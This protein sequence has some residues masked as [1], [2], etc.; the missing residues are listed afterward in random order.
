MNRAHRFKFA[1]LAVLVAGFLA[2]WYGFGLTLGIDLQ[3]G[4]EL[5]YKLDFS[6]LPVNSRNA[7]TTDA[8][9]DIL[10]RRLD[11]LQLKEMAMRRAGQ[12][13][14]LIQLPGMSEQTKEQIKKVIASAGNLWFKIVVERENPLWS[15]EEINKIEE[16]KAKNE[17]DPKDWDFDTART[18]VTATSPV[19]RIEL[20]RN[21]DAVD[22]KLLETAEAGPDK[23][24]IGLAVHFYM[25]PAGRARMGQ[26]TERWV[27]NRMAI[28]LDGAIQSA[29]NINEPITEG[30][31]L[32]EGKDFTKD[33]IDALVTVLKSGAL[34]A[35]PSLQS[36]NSV[37]P[38]LGADS[39]RR[40]M[41][42]IG[43]S[44]GLIVLFMF[45]YYGWSGFIA[46]V[47]LVVNLILLLGILALFEA[48][49]TLPGIAGVVLTMGM[50]VDAN[51]LINERM[52][53]ERERGLP[54]PEVVRVGY[55]HAFSAIFDGH[56]TAILTAIILYFVGTGPIRGFAVT[57]L[58]GVT[59]SLFT[60]VWV[61]R[62]VIDWAV[63]HQWLKEV[64]YV[65][66]LHGTN[67][68]FIRKRM[69]LIVISLVL[70]NL[71]YVA[72]MF[73]GS[74]KYG[75]DFNGGSIVQMHLAKPMT[76]EEA[77]ARLTAYTVEVDGK[78]THPYEGRVEPQAL[79]KADENRRYRTIELRL[80]SRGEE[81]PAVNTASADEKPE[82]SR[83]VPV[84]A[85][86]TA[87]AEAE[88]AAGADTPQ[89]RFLVDVRRLFAEE[90]VPPAFS[91]T[92]IEDVAGKSG[93]VR[94]AV[95]VR[96][97]AAA[98]AD[99]AVAA[100]IDV[101]ALA[102]ALQDPERGNFPGAE[103]T[104]EGD[105]VH[106]R[107]GLVDLTAKRRE[108]Y[109]TAMK[110]V[111]QKQ[112]ARAM[113]NPF[114]FQTSIGSSVAKN[115]KSRA[116][117]AIVLSLIGTIVY[118]AFRFEFKA[119]L[120]AALC[121]FHDVL[122]ALGF[123]MIF[124]LTSKYTGIDAKLNLSSIAAFL[125]I[126]GYSIT[127]TI[128]NFDRMRENLAAARPKDRNAYEDVIEKSINQTL[129]RTLLTSF[130]VFLVLIVLAFAGVPS[131][132]GFTLALLVG[133]I[134]GT[135]SSISVATPI[136]LVAPRK[137]AVICAL[138]LGFF[139]VVGIAGR[140]VAG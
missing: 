77:G 26:I 6:K 98:L 56:V 24:G 17:Y 50:A 21:E 76:S 61:T 103:V 19:A 130:T 14:I 32:I 43:A 13:Q 2:A 40:G 82:A 57:L 115:L 97:D 62:A 42:A 88:G 68:P 139:I 89:A 125:T 67:I 22:G 69:P 138:Q 81:E 126:I 65:R 100:S 37:A 129:A 8:T 111:I 25:R 45:V 116:I 90:L 60:A 52:R 127:D 74:D 134:F 44:V 108:S 12:D 107:T 7:A 131:L 112:L 73:R 99:P 55:S 27:K 78:K 109:E 80:T 20:L 122:V 84:A 49:L 104:R 38:T 59:L 29:P 1:F 34:P 106:V 5:I 85:T 64:R 16:A 47:A 110:G 9:I 91:E 102:K 140:Y 105:V 39:V 41:I 95:D 18:R 101:E 72:F 46:N 92:K 94:L 66:F 83:P 124:D 117:L 30:S 79:G 113:S 87:V 120:A 119:G 96:L 3:G 51:I 118:L 114:P 31:G 58:I 133:V 28:V 48:T 36:E 63:E 54:L 11:T 4:S 121:L 53:E 23:Y 33:E 71:G 135:Y 86:A 128:V 35:K 93:E 132:M 75:I 136:L 15:Q 10:S 137:L 123:M 70:Y